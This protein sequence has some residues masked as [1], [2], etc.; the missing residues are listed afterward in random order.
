[1]LRL[2]TM[3]AVLAA[4]AAAQDGL[5]A[6]VGLPDQERLACF[7]ALATAPVCEVE[8]WT[9]NHASTMT[10]ITGSSACEAGK[11]SVRVFAADGTTFLG[12]TVA[13][14]EGHA[15]QTALPLSEQPAEI[16]VKFSFTE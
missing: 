11:V 14:I 9:F 5:A 10:L 1:M 8:G 15:F 16:T 3:I 2:A 6:C 13:Y 4:P 7:D 12:S